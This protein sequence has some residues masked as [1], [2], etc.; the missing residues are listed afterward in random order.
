[1]KT[2]WTPFSVVPE[3]NSQLVAALVAPPREV[4]PA[5]LGP[6]VRS[7][8]TATGRSEVATTLTSLLGSNALTLAT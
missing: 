5:P 4:R 1:V 8:S 7:R 3:A 6:K 2:V